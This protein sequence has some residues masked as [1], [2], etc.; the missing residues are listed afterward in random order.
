LEQTI[1]LM[2]MEATENQVVESIIFKRKIS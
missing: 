2:H 1:K